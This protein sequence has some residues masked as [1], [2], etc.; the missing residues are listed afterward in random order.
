MR[1]V[2]YRSSIWL[3]ILWAFGSCGCGKSGQ[4]SRPPVAQIIEKNRAMTEAK[5]ASLAAISA[6]AL[7]HPELVEPTGPAT[8][9]RLDFADM[10]REPAE[11]LVDSDTW[12][13]LVVGEAALSR[14]G[15]VGESWPCREFSPS[16]GPAAA[17]ELVRHGT[18]NGSAM[19]DGPIRRK[20]VERYFRQL[21]HMEYVV[22]LRE[23][24]Y[25]KSEIVDGLVGDKRFVPGKWM[26]EARLFEI[27]SGDYLGGVLDAATISADRLTPI[28]SSAEDIESALECALSAEAL[29]NLGLAFRKH[30]PNTTPREIL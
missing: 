14:F 21:E 27:A 12:N 3:L 13:V 30:I 8:G 24:L 15:A 25:E 28:G 18:V 4:D 6:A 23:I 7:Q 9:I 20:I 19:E 16:G 5:L 17:M 29:R 11:G 1:R 26:A 2:G 10:S 22:V